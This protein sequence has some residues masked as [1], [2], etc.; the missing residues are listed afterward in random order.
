M[1]KTKNRKPR[2]ARVYFGRTDE[3]GRYHFMQLWV[4][5]NSARADGP[6]LRGQ[7]FF[8]KPEP[9]PVGVEY[10]DFD[11]H[12]HPRGANTESELDAMARAWVTEGIELEPTCKHC[13][14]SAPKHTTGPYVHEFEAVS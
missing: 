13:G 7:C 3:L 2:V 8:T 1:P 14:M 11:L 10:R 12:W 4:D 5:F 9:L 6:V